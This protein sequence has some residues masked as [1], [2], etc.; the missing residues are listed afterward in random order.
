MIQGT[1]SQHSP[2]LCNIFDA[3][4]EKKQA[5]E[6]CITHAKIVIQLVD[7]LKRP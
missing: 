5:K 6:L 4:P 2:K 7:K 3:Q 1:L